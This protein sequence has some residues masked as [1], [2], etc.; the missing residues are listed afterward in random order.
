[1]MVHYFS[2]WVFIVSFSASMPL[3]PLVHL[4]VLGVFSASMCLVPC[5]HHVLVMLSCV[6]CFFVLLVA[7]IRVLFS[8]LF[9][10]MFAVKC[11]HARVDS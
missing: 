2:I 9:V 11:F 3:V 8:I 6:C 4:L 5:V 1:M 7:F 10:R